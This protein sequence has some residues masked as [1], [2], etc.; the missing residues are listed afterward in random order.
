MIAIFDVFPGGCGYSRALTPERL[1]AFFRI[2]LKFIKEKS[3]D[4]ND[5]L[6]LHTRRD[7]IPV[8]KEADMENF[9]IFLTNLLSLQ[10]SAELKQKEREIF[11]R[12]NKEILEVK[13]KTQERQI[14]DQLPPRIKKDYELFKS[15]GKEI[16]K[17]WPA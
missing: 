1:F 4:L 3:P 12:L 11:K 10:E 13:R 2:I 7:T 8:F 15:I 6:V 5:I 14:L 16:N 9:S 17:Q